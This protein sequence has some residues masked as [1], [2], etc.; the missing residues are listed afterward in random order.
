MASLDQL[1]KGLN[2]SN[3]KL[4]FKN[5]NNEFNNISDELNNLLR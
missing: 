5:F 2:S 3:N 4:L 1:V